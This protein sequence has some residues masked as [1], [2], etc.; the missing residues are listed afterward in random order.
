MEPWTVR[1]KGALQTITNLLP[2]LSTRIATDNS[3]DALP[4]AIA[5]HVVGNRPDRFEPQVR[6]RRPK[7]YKLLHEPRE[8]YKKRM[9]AWR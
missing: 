5:A 6:R 2:L 3:C 9:A 4:E 1:F 8:A 7:S